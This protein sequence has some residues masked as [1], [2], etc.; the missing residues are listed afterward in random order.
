MEKILVLDDEEAIQILYADELRE[1]GYEVV[2]TADGSRIIELIRSEQPDLVVLDIKLI[3]HDGLDLLQDIRNRYYNLPVILCTAY[4]VFK[5]DPKS[6]AADYYVV[7]S[8]SMEE[9]K[10]RIRM[11]LEADDRNPQETVFDQAYQASAR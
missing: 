5:H 2:T 4:S 10:L 7:K 6:I 3:E 8:S 1:E 11:A 9:L